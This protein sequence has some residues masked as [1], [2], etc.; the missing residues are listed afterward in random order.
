MLTDDSIEYVKGKNAD[1]AIEDNPEA[2]V[3]VIDGQC[4]YD[5]PVYG[6]LV[7]MFTSH[8]EVIDISNEYPDHDGIVVRFMK[9]GAVVEEL[10]TTE[11]FGSILLSNPQVLDL[12][13]YPY[14]RY[15]VSPD[16]QFDGEKFI[17]TNRDVSKM[18]AW[19][20]KNPQ[21]PK[22]YFEDWAKK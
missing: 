13:K 5:I 14:G 17:I 3:W 8:D 9:D 1:I 19:H 16:A 15:V 20:P 21:A 11:Y 12:N 22:E 2:L 6:Y 4:V 18:M 10:K 7:Q